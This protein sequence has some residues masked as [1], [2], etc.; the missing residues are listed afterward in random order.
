MDQQNLT[1]AKIPILDTGKFEQWQFRIQQYL[2]HEHYAL[3]EVI[4]FG[5]SYEAPKDG[6]ASA[7][8]GAT[9][10][11]KNSCIKHGSGNEEVNTASVSTASTNVSPVSANIG[12]ASISQDT[13]CAYIA[14]QS[15]EKDHA[16]VV[17]EESP[18]EFALIAKT[19]AGSEITVR[20]TINKIDKVEIAKKPAVK[21]AEQYRKPTKKSN[22][23]GNQRNW[24]NLKSQQLGE[25]FVMINKACFNCSHFDHLSYNSGLGVK[26]GRS[27]P[28]NNYTHK[29]MPPR[30]AIH[31][32]YRPSM[33]PARPNINAAQPKRTSFHKPAH[34][35]R[36]FQRI[37]KFKSQF[38]AP[39]VP[40]VNRKFPTVNRNFPL[41][42]ENFPLVA[43]NFPLLIW[44][45]KETMLR[46]QLDVVDIAC[47][48]YSQEVLGFSDVIASGNP[49]PYYDP[50]VFARSSRE[51]DFILEEVDAFLA[52]KDDPTSLEVDQSY[53]DT[54]GDILL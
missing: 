54:E 23:R 34:S 32:P 41:L 9:K 8:D 27:C 12:A 31:K 10:K 45:R 3:W 36:P 37:S 29:C 16:L 11:K 21:Y 14:S 19:S 22:V 49:T 26:K 44:E 30:P 17:D 51:S 7:S 20:P 50:I 25:N 5:D 42:T 46:P 38:R 39:W 15:N 24:N 1:I 2:Q 33:R 52:L 28:K 13:A 35:Y 53:V 48:E 4:E 40:T 18:T 6:A 47:K 43:Q